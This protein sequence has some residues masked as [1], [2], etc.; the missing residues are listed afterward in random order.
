MDFLIKHRKAF[1]TLL[2]LV[3]LFAYCWS[4][5]VDKEKYTAIYRHGIE[6]ID[7]GNYQ[8]GLR[9]LTELGDFQD[10]LKYIEEARNGIMF[11]QAEVDYYKG[12]YDKAKEAFT[13]L[14][15]KPDFKKADEARVYIEKI[16]AKLSEKDPRSADYDEANRL[17][18]SG[19][20][21]KAMDIFS[22]LGEYEQS[23][24]MAKRCDIA[25]KIIS[26]STTI[27]AGTQISAGVTTDGSAEACGNNPIT[28]EVREWKNIVSISV[29]GSLAVGLRTDGTVVTAG[30]L[31]DPYRIETGNWEDI[32]SVSVGDL[33]VVGLRSN[34]TLV[35]QGYNGDHQMDIDDWTNIKYID[36]GWRHTVGLTYD[37]KVK[38]AGLRRGDEK[39]IENNPEWNDIIMI[40]AGGGDPR[41]TGGKGHTV[42]LKSDGTVVAIGDNSK[43]Q[44]NVNGPEWRD[45]VSIAAGEFHTVGLTKDGDIVTT[46]EGSKEDIAKWKEDGYKM[47]AISAG[48]G[49]TFALDTEGGVHCTG[50]DKQNQLKIDD[51]DK[52][53]VHPEEWKSTQPDFY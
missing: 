53:A 2:V 38:I 9:I 36:T 24:E 11:D 51:W 17:L 22:S 43:G 47:I 42:G 16:D 4:I 5:K 14:S 29:F 52:L 18:E 30:R 39:L 7:A 27:S 44:C 31:N 40:A 32:V 46:N 10:S 8:E 37:G 33:Y 48:Y 50:Y 3:F 12:N 41:P 34:G 1:L 49:T 13:E 26:R 35:A 20:Y 28:E 19:N 25:M 23:K 6:Q 45:I 15:N 21:E